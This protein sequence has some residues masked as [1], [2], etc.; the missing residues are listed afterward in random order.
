MSVQFL[1]NVSH[2]SGDITSIYHY[3]IFLEFA[4]N[5]YYACLVTLN[6]HLEAKF[7]SSSN[8]E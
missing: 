6:S 2:W 8:S 5:I 4:S 1:H 3:L 7:S